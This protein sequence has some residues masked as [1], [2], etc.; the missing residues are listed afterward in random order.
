MNL[1]KLIKGCKKGK[2]EYQKELYKRYSSSLYYLAVRYVKAPEVAQDLLHDAFIIIYDKIKSYKGSGSFEGWIKKVMINVCLSY[3]R[4]NKKEL[5]LVSDHLEDL[6]DPIEEDNKLLTID[7][8]LRLLSRLPMGT[9]SVFNLYYLEGYS[10]K[11][12]AEVLGIS[13]GTSKSQLSR[14][15]ELLRVELKKNGESYAF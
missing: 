3:L 1:D 5:R 13:V 7:V 4:R 14:A 15:R 10:H 11:E 12:I 6:S 9:R 2:L 8:I